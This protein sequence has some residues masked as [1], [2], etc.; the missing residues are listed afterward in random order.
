M[1][2]KT[3]LIFLLLLMSAVSLLWGC[4]GTVPP[5][6]PGTD[7]ALCESSDQCRA[8]LICIAGHCG[9]GRPDA[10]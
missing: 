1:L 2:K 9:G 10:R 3:G 5:N 6:L 8:P 7:G 4:T